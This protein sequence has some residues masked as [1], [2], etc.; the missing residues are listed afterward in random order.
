MKRIGSSIWKVKNSMISLIRWSM[1]GLI[2]L[3]VVLLLF[4]NLL[5]AQV[6]VLYDDAMTIGQIYSEAYLAILQSETAMDRFFQYRDIAAFDRALERL[7]DAKG[8]LETIDGYEDPAFKRLVADLC[9]MI[10]TCQ[11]VNGDARF[12]LEKDVNSGYQY[13]IDARYKYELLK[14]VY[15]DGWNTE[16]QI[17]VETQKKAQESGRIAETTTIIVMAG[18]FI[19][20]TALS[21]HVT[22]RTRSTIKALNDYS[23]EFSNGNLMVPELILT[24]N[25]FKPMVNTLNSMV[26]EIRRN[27]E[28]RELTKT[29]E[30]QLA[31]ETIQKVRIEAELRKSQIKEMQSK[32][33]PHFLFNTLNLITCTAYLEHAEKTR[34]L[35]EALAILLRRTIDQSN[36]LVTVRE[37]V[38]TLELYILIQKERFEG[39]IEFHVHVDE[40]LLEERI[41]AVFLQPIVENSVIHGLKNKIGQGNV[42]V[43][44]YS[45]NNF[46]HIE[47]MDDGCGMQRD[48]IQQ[49]LEDRVQ[50]GDHFGLPAVL[51]RI[52][53]IYGKENARIT[54]ESEIDNYTKMF[55]ELPRMKK[56]KEQVL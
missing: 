24:D 35:M 10:E 23:R 30:L 47:I 37:E 20:A 18:S 42:F 3:F 5:N 28:E 29:L 21:I 2:A 8:M 25:D 44:I 49:L 27:V 26:A 56:G 46:I 38:E 55:F 36:A 9:K 22:R 11:Q 1:F 12:A 43:R 41:P 50:P 52:H 32:L 34:R 14:M 16:L 13:I 51:K 31:N 15:S 48:F 53:L 17:V 33:N 45:H 4:I 40:D 19:I 6:R 39:R 7:N 54:I